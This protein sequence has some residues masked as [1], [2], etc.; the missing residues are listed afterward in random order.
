[1]RPKVIFLFILLMVFVFPGPVQGETR[2]TKTFL[3][4]KSEGFLLTGEWKWKYHPGDNKQW[5]EPGYDDHLWE[6][7]YFSKDIENIMKTNWNNVGWF[8][9]RFRIDE[10]LQGKPAALY[11][12]HLG[13][14]EVFL[15]GKPI[16]RFGQTNP[17]APVEETAEPVRWKAFAFDRRSRQVIAVRYFNDS[18]VSQQRMGFNTGFYLWFMDIDKTLPMVSRQNMLFAKY[19]ALLTAIP[20]LLALLHLFLFIFYPKLKENLFYSFCLIGYAA[21]FYTI[22]NRYVTSDPGEMIFYFRMGPILNTLTISFLLLTSYSIVYA[23]IPKRYRYFIVSAVIVG[24]WGAFKPLGSIYIGLYLFTTLLIFESLRVFIR[25][26]PREKKGAWI[27]LIG[28]ATLAILSVYQAGDVIVEMI[29]YQTTDPPRSYF[30]VHT[31][32]GPVLIVCMSIYLSYHFSRINKYL[33]T[34]LAQVK[35]LS[36]KNLLQERRARKMISRS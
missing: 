10:T 19:E 36:E 35:E 23:K 27:I 17:P 33:E 24:A 12:R 32:G 20:L 22:M 8:R 3:E 16:H 31:Y 11:I 34:K 4:E 26:W 2:L 28:I 18:T 5:A 15:N 29:A 25:H 9:C 14:S 1:M 30:R 13:A 7:I 6:N 21:F